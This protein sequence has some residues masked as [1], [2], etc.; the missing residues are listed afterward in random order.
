MS[1]KLHVADG[2]RLFVVAVVTFRFSAN[3]KVPNGCKP[4]SLMLLPIHARADE[5]DKCRIHPSWVFQQPNQHD[6]RM[7][8]W[9]RLNLYFF[10]LLLLSRCVGC[11]VCPNMW[12]CL[13]TLSLAIEDVE[14]IRVTKE[15]QGLQ[16]WMDVTR[17]LIAHVWYA[18]ERV[19]LGRLNL[20]K[21]S[22]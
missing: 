2:I 15:I 10:L 5:S 16:D 13:W 14:A 11:A 7:L 9:I 18:L 20:R 3:Q 1:G 12:R 4:L 21:V 6:S 22:R 19:L 17:C 8:R